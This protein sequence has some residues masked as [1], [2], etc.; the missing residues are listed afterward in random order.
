MP[1]DAFI[2]LAPDWVC[3]VLSPSTRKL[4]RSEKM[5]VYA[6]E[7]VS[8]LWFVEPTDHLLEV[9]RLTDG[10]WL[11]VGS[12]HDDDEVRAEPFDAVPLNL[13]ALWV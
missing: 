8:H 10:T 12:W 5:D 4:D 3:E 13:G 9:F 1:S 6:R 7:G 2:T 11:R